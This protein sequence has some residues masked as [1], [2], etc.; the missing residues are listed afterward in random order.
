VTLLVFHEKKSIRPRL[1]LTEDDYKILAKRYQLKIDEK[2]L[3]RE[4]I[5]QELSNDHKKR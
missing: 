4:K 1:S 2:G 3:I 5:K